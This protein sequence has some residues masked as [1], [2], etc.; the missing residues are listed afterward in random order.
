MR[1]HKRLELWNVLQLAR[2]FAQA[3]GFNDFVKF[4]EH[5]LV[6]HA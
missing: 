2:S 6:G 5:L 4:R 1:K 3:E